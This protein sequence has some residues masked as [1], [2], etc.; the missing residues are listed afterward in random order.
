MRLLNEDKSKRL[1][2]KTFMM[3]DLTYPLH[4]CKSDDLF[5]VMGHDVK[6]LLCNLDNSDRDTKGETG[7]GKLLLNL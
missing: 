3:E 4:M 1:K 6:I 5:D 7:C 2:Y